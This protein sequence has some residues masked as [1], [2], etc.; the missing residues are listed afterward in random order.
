MGTGDGPVGSNSGRIGEIAPSRSRGTF[1]Q[2]DMS[3]VGEIEAKTGVL[4]EDKAGGTPERITAAQDNQIDWE[5]KT[6]EFKAKIADY[7]KDRRLQM[8]GFWNKYIK[9]AKKGEPIQEPDPEVL[10]NDIERWVTNSKKQN[11][12]LLKSIDNY[13]NHEILHDAVSD[14][15]TPQ[16]K[17][18]K[19]K[20]LAKLGSKE[21][22]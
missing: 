16:E 3:A 14:Y 5:T 19:E 12:P 1:Q 15:Q 2:D 13:A 7:Q 9:A 4:G 6:A 10:N 18:A 11:S 20:E 17:V 22:E 21:I 8:T